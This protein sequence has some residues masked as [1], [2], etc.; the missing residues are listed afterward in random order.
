MSL[1]SPSMLSGFG[2]QLFR[3]AYYFKGAPGTLAA[4]ELKSLCSSTSGPL[5]DSF[6]AVKPNLSAD[7]HQAVYDL[8]SLSGAITHNTYPKAT[9]FARLSSALVKAFAPINT[10][11]G[12][13]MAK[14]SNMK[15][16]TAL[17]QSYRVAHRP[18]EA[19]DLGSLSGETLYNPYRAIAAPT[20]PASSVTLAET[21]K[22]Q[23][24]ALQDQA[25]LA[26]IAE[27]RNLIKQGVGI[28]GITLNRGSV[29]YQFD[30][31]HPAFQEAGDMGIRIIEHSGI[32]DWN[33]LGVRK[34]LPKNF[35]RG[36]T[37]PIQ[38]Q[39]T[40]DF[41]GL[42]PNGTAVTFTRQA[43]YMWQPPLRA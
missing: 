2:R 10:T 30:L 4:K 22:A 43:G 12:L 26:Q 35:S 8:S 28:D 18:V 37:K 33:D 27:V 14:L 13:K 20:R 41:R 3:Q 42:H 38:T 40:Y 17:E 19:F 6:F 29:T 36:K 11:N 39:T 5:E 25:A 9:L 24:L 34:L 31:E 16:A 1:L 23:K 21:S 15:R 32:K 7:T